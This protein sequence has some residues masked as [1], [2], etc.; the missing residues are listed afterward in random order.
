MFFPVM[1]IFVLE[2]TQSKKK[3]HFNGDRGKS[4][5]KCVLHEW[6]FPEL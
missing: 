6:F 1:G 2:I 3:L 4:E 5:A